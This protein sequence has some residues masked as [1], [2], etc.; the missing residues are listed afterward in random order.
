MV[1]VCGKRP[2]CTITGWSPA[3]RCAAFRNG[4][5]SGSDVE[6]ARTFIPTTTSALAAIASAVDAS[7]RL[8]SSLAISSLWQMKSL[9]AK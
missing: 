8:R 4:D 7:S 2:R 9:V 1:G 6:H 5:T 3:T